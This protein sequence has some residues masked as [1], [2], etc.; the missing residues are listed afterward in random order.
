LVWSFHSRS[1]FTLVRRWINANKFIRAIP[2]RLDQAEKEWHEAQPITEVMPEFIEHEPDG[3]EAQSLLGGTI[4][5]RHTFIS[6]DE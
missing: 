6:R 3:S 4:Q 5:A 1:L 2:I